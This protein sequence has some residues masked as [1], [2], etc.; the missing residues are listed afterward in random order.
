MSPV[1]SRSRPSST[2]L[3]A[4]LAIVVAGIVVVALLV[5]SSSGDHPSRGP[6][7]SIFQDDQLLLYSPP[8]TVAKTLDTLRALGVDR[9]RATVLW[10]AL[11]PAATSATEPSNFSATDPAAYGATAWAPYD[12]LTRLAAARGIGVDFNVT[13][14]G[15]AHV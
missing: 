10:L 5:S 12:R 9:V 8:Q 3:A 7:D 11:A 4:A 13:E 6:V 1:R 2:L 14:I 15:R